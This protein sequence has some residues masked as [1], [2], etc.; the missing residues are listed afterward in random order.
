MANHIER[1]GVNHCAKTAEMNHWMFREQPIDDIGIDAYIEYVDPSGKSKQLLGLQ[2]KSGRSWF[3]EKKENCIIFRSISERQFVYW[4][5]NSLP[6]IIV[7]F[8]PDDETCIWQELS[9]KTII[10]TKGGKGNGF[11]V[12]VP[13]KQVFL[14]DESNSLLLS[15]TNLPEYVKNYNFLLSQK[16]FMDVIQNG[17]SVKLHSL[18]WVNKSSGRGE[19]EL[20]VNNGT[21]TKKYTYPYWFPFTMYTDVFPRLFPWAN[22]TADEEYYEENDESTWKELNCYYDKEDDDW[23]VVGDSFEAF[24]KQLN[25]MRSIDHAGEVAE[26]M[27]VLSINDFGKAFLKVNAFVSHSQAYVETRPER[28]ENGQ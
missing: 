15:L 24:R 1:I 13:L 19:T 21:E 17:G 5:T 12:Q 3:D 16:S 11:F 28:N 9:S 6:C 4:T 7:L 18:E 2:I 23:I 22:F 27:L 10:K 14:D 8:N 26:Y 20:I 25:P